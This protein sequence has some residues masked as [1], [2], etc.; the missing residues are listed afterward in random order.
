MRAALSITDFPFGW[1]RYQDAPSHG[2]DAIAA[3]IPECNSFKKVAKTLRH[4]H[5]S[6]GRRDFAQPPESLANNTVAVFT[7][8][9][10][11]SGALALFGRD[12]LARCLQKGL[13]RE[14][15][16]ILPQA[17]PGTTLKS[18]NVARLAVDPA[19]DRTVAYE[20]TISVQVGTLAQSFK[21][22]MQ[23][24]QVGRSAAF[25]Y[26]YEIAPSLRSSLVTAVLNRLHGRTSGSLA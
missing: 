13:G 1:H 4:A 18:V 12:E 10:T 3:T 5:V 11:A 17:S 16:Q 9:K 23:V 25:F 24:S 15:R 2:F 20:A 26:F 6:S 22:E 19:G 7:S 14:L 21:A 8:A